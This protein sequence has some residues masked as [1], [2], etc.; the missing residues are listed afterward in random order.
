MIGRHPIRNRK[1]V[2]LLLTL[3]VVALLAASTITFIRN[4]HLE[5][6]IADNTYAYTQA[7]IL[8]RAGLK[9]AMTILAMDDKKYDALTDPWGDFE[10]YAAMAGSIFEEGSFTGRIED[11]SGRVNLNALIDSG[12]LV[13]D[14]QLAILTRLFEKLEIDAEPIPA[15]LDW[16]DPDDEVRL[17]GAENAYYLSLK[18]PYPCANGPVLTQGRL[19][20]IKGLTDR[21]L[22]GTD[23]RPGLLQFVTVDSEGKININTAPPVVLQCLDDDLTPDA[24]QAIMERRAVEPFEKLDQLRDIPGLTPVILARITGLL[25]VASSH[26]RI[27]IEGRYRQATVRL[28]AIVQRSGDVVKLTYF[29]AG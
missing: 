14:E 2:A 25:S 13:V 4:T 28:N 19:T 7:D 17:G 22:R 20:L 10:R 24:V 11:L 6:Q 18:K 1:G 5:A 21:V 26:F 3:L 8:A 15:V 16:L 23:E 12:G 27:S 29:R 9:G